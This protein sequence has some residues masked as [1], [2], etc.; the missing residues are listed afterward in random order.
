[1]HANKYP[2]ALMDRLLKRLANGEASLSSSKK[3]KKDAT[4][5][6][7]SAAFR[8]QYFKTQYYKSGGKLFCKACN[9]V[10]NHTRR[11]VIKQHLESK[12]LQTSLLL[13]NVLN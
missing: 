6:K 10:I 7:I 11:F 12:K 2:T 1:M 8:A 13:R 4:L 9:V 5:G 3:P